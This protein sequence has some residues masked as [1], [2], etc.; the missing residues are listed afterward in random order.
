MQK[1]G[2]LKYTATSDNYE[3]SMANVCPKIVSPFTM[4]NVYL[5]YFFQILNLVTQNPLSLYV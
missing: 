4:M 3:K 5:F 1:A 2:R